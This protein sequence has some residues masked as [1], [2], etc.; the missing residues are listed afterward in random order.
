LTPPEPAAGAGADA[1]L[2]SA[3]TAGADAAPE[4]APAAD[5]TPDPAP[6]RGDP[7]PAAVRA[8]AGTLR[9]AGHEA[10]LVGGCVRD[11][12]RGVEPADWDLTTNARPEQVVALFSGARYENRFGTVEIDEGGGTYEVTTYRHDGPYTDHRRPDAVLFG[13]RLDDDLARRD[14][15]VNAMALDVGTEDGTSSEAGTWPE[16]GASAED[17]T[18][19]GAIHDPFGGRADLGARLLRAVGDPA[20][21]FREDSLRMLRAVRFAATLGFAVEERTLAAIEANAPLA[22][23]LSGE[24]VL[25]EVLT[26]LTAPVPSVGLRLAQETG[27][28][29]AI[30]PE[31]AR[32]RGVLQGKVPGEDLWDHTCRTVDAA[33]RPRPD[34]PPLLRLAALLHDVGKP[35][36][37]ADGHFVGHDAVGASLTEVW[38]TGLHAP[39]FLTADTANLVRHHMFAYGAS[40]TD[41][42]VRRF[43]RR[44]GATAV[45]DLLDLRAADNVGSG[46]AADVDGLESLRARCHE[47]LEARVALDLSGLAVDGDDLMKALDIPPGPAVGVLLDRLLE[48]VVADPMLNDRSRLLTVARELVAPGIVAAGNETPATPGNGMPGVAQT[49]PSDETGPA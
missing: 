40:W 48:R 23:S 36:T 8:I 38:L 3:P 1:A 19:P 16:P 41:A 10:H 4:S 26:L 44:C 29:A 39:R 27:L 31:L 33:P 32:Q 6:G 24:R 12:L 14:F 34:E 30:A 43:I 18:R 46:L 25:A 35:A 13:E 5:S 15:T 2:E 20:A 42:A 11:L 17:S 45:D 37:F 22:G 47:Q 28:L 21:R 7:I 9:A 49:G